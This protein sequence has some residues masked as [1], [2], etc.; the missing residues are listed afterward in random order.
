MRKRELECECE[1]EGKLRTGDGDAV[2]EVGG[3]ISGSRTH[4]ATHVW[5]GSIK[6]SCVL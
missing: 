5:T 2:T 4:S 1:K 3:G 6:R